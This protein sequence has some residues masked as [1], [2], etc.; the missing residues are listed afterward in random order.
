MMRDVSCYHSTVRYIVGSE[1]KGGRKRKLDEVDE[2]MLLKLSVSLKTLRMELLTSVYNEA[3]GGEDPISIS[4]VFRF[5][6]R[7]K[8]T[9]KLLTRISNL[10]DP[11]RISEYLESISTIDPCLLVSIDETSSCRGKKFEEKRGRAESGEDAVVWLFKINDIQF[12][13]IA[14][15]STIGFLAWRIFLGTVEHGA[16]ESFLK[17]EVAPI[18]ADDNVIIIDNASVHKTR[19]TLS[20]L[21]DISGDRYA[22]LPEYENRLAPIERGFSNMWRG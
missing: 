7:N 5:L 18:L 13:V 1:E 11:V 12:S 21:R 14:A 6:K 22:F 19:S 4:G 3:R 9:T 20:T 10:K 16:V 15:Y 2:R 8:V 17:E